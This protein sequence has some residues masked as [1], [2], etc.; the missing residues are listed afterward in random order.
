[1]ESFKW[2]RIKSVQATVQEAFGE[3]DPILLEFDIVPFDYKV[4]DLSSCQMFISMNKLATVID[5]LIEVYDLHSLQFS[6]IG[7]EPQFMLWEQL[8]ERN[9]NLFQE[10]FPL[11][12]SGLV[13]DDF[14]RFVMHEPNTPQKQFTLRRGNACAKAFQTWAMVETIK[15]LRNDDE[16]IDL[17]NM[18]YGNFS[19][20]DPQFFV[21]GFLVFIVYV[22]LLVTLG[23]ILPQMVVYFLH[24]VFSLFCLI[25]I[26]W[27][28]W[29]MHLN[30]KRYAQIYERYKRGENDRDS[31]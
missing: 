15:K 20:F 11:N 21:F 18:I 4:K 10:N 24:A 30:T 2:D 8:L 28:V 5:D 9:I 25:F 14:F 31:T 23:G 26:G 6:Y 22:L 3:D 16:D 13:D 7:K 29:T 17:H 12:K 27:M 19:T 1:M